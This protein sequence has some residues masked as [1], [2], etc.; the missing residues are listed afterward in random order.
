LARESTNEQIEIRYFALAGFIL[1]E[2]LVDV[3]VYA[4]PLAEP[5]FIATPSKLFRLG[6]GW[7]PLICPN[8]LV[9]TC[10]VEIE[11]RM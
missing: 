8:S 7:F 3:L 9:W 5:L 11:F 10:R 4:R 1:V 6:S 2:N